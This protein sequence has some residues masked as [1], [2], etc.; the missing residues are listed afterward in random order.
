MSIACRNWASSWSAPLTVD[1]LQVGKPC[2]GPSDPSHFLSFKQTGAGTSETLYRP[3]KFLRQSISD[4]EVGCRAVLVL[5]QK[6]EQIKCIAV[7]VFD[8]LRLH[9]AAAHPD[10]IVTPLG[11]FP[12]RADNFRDFPDIH[13]LGRFAVKAHGKVEQL[14]MYPTGSEN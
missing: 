3:V 10:V 5:P 13:W 7:Q 14:L 8:L 4:P 6:R 12:D 2:D 9:V 1:R 11:H